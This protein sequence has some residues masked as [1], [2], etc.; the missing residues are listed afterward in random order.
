AATYAIGQE[1][2]F[3]WYLLQ[4]GFLS[5]R[6]FLDRPAS[7]DASFRLLEQDRREDRL[8]A[9]DREIPFSYLPFDVL[10]HF[11]LTQLLEKSTA[12][13]FI[14]QP[15]DGDWKIMPAREAQRLL[16]PRVHVI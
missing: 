12:A 2:I 6:Q 15:I 10:R 8:T 14:L 4:N 13:G 7:L 9:F 11:D 1:Q 16:P 5:Y 3:R